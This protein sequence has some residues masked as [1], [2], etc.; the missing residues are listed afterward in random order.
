[1]M[2]APYA[3]YLLLLTAAAAKMTTAQAAAPASPLPDAIFTS[4][5]I[6]KAASW[7]A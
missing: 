1:M 6:T 3:G 7:D 4:A 5:P 2:S